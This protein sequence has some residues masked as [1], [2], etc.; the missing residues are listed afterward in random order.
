MVTDPPPKIRSGVE[1]LREINAL[2]LKKAIEIGENDAN[3]PISKLTGWKKKSF[4]LG[5]SILEHE[6]H[7]T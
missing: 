2:G 1:L 3:V 5:F 6:S 4:F 7:K